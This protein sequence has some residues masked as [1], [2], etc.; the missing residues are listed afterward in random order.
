MFLECRMDRPAAPS[1]ENNWD[2]SELANSVSLRIQGNPVVLRFQP[3]RP[4]K[5]TSKI[6][7]GLGVKMNQSL[8]WSSTG[9]L[10]MTSW[11]TQ[12]KEMDHALVV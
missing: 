6:N 11:S 9:E 12:L 4:G 2:G 5:K 10:G 1:L 7:N 8:S 3:Q